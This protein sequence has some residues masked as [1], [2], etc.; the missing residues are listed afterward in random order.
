M[1][2][3]VQLSITIHIHV[4]PLGRW[5]GVS[6]SGGPWKVFL[7]SRRIA[8]KRP[9]GSDSLSLDAANCSHG[10][11]FRRLLLTV[12]P[13]IVQDDYSGRAAIPKAEASG[14]TSPRH[15]VDRPFRLGL[16]GRRCPG[17]PGTMWDS[18]RSVFSA[19]VSRRLRQPPDRST[20]GNRISA[21]EDE[22]RPSSGAS[23]RA[24][25]WRTDPAE[26]R[27][28]PD[29]PRLAPPSPLVA[30]RRWL[31]TPLAGVRAEISPRARTRGGRF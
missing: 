11:P 26:S 29:H 3:D 30:S 16:I 28:L 8:R 25:A 24:G 27:N 10:P 7:S 6:G 20:R 18:H 13:F 4:S 19:F 21:D 17:D 5:A 12:L 14:A 1:V 23:A 22:L 15:R 2:L 31:H 9:G